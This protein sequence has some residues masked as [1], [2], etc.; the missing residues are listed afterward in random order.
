M[1][2]DYLKNFLE[3]LTMKIIEDI[4]DEENFIS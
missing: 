3:N 4:E 1:R 2:Q